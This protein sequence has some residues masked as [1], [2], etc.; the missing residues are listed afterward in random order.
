[1]RYVKTTLCAAGVLGA[2][3]T[4]T[5]AL[6]TEFHAVREPNECSEAEPCKTVGKGVGTADEAHPGWAAEFQLGNFKILCEKAHT[7]AATAADG[8]LVAETSETFKTKVKFSKCLTAAKFGT[9]TGGLP[10]SF[11]GGA[12]IS[13]E[14]RPNEE[15]PNGVE[16]GTVVL[17]EAR[18]S[19]AIANKICKLGWGG[20]VVKSHAENPVATFS[21]QEETVTTSKRFPEGLR[22]RLEIA[23][24]FKGIEYEYE[25]GQCV[26]EG[27]FEEG[28]KKTEG[29]SGTFKGNFLITL[30]GGS[31]SAE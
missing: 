19:F 12:P 31:I 14:Y 24:A 10:T 11:N 23:N 5:P 30:T 29:K 28:A 25:E 17:G 21:T 6:A 18:A 7:E 26:G 4:A 20:Q 27:G 9:F 1:M 3:L 15:L 16:G 8:A 2:L 22:D 13:I